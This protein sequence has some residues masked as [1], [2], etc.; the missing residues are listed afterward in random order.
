MS[1]TFNADTPPQQLYKQAM[2]EINRIAQE[3]G[4]PGFQNLGN[5]AMN[6]GHAIGFELEQL[7]KRID[8][9]SKESNPNPREY[10]QR[11]INEFAIPDGN[12]AQT[13]Q[14]QEKLNALLNKLGLNDAPSAGVSVGV[15]FVEE[16]SLDTLVL[17]VSQRADYAAVYAR[18][19]APELS[20]MSDE[21]P[22]DELDAFFDAHPALDRSRQADNA[23][24]DDDDFRLEGEEDPQILETSAIY[25]PGLR[26]AD[27]PAKPAREFGEHE[28]MSEFA[29]EVYEQMFSEDPF[30][31]LAEL[32]EQ[33]DREL[34][35]KSGTKNVVFRQHLQN[36]LPVVMLAMAG[37]REEW[38][39][40]NKNNA[41]NQAE[42][43]QR[44]QAM[45]AVFKMLQSMEIMTTNRSQFTQDHYQKKINQIMTLAGEPDGQRLA[46]ALDRI[47]SRNV[48]NVDDV[49]YN[50][51]QH[52]ISAFDPDKPS[53][54]MRGAARGLQIEHKRSE[55]EGSTAVVLSGK[56]H[57]S[58]KAV[59]GVQTGKFSGVKKVFAQRQDNLKEMKSQVSE[60]VNYALNDY[61]K[62]TSANPIYLQPANSNQSELQL[63]ILM[64]FKK[65]AVLEGRTL[66]ASDDD[67]N[68]IEITPS[69][70]FTAK[71]KQYFAHYAMKVPEVRVGAIGNKKADHPAAYHLFKDVKVDNKPLKDH[72]EQSPELL[73]KAM[74]SALKENV[75]FSVDRQKGLIE[76]AANQI[77]ERDLGATMRL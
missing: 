37:A 69:L 31:V 14:I 46:E 34:E 72:K 16:G 58:R 60:F 2:T 48:I 9:A 49:G 66:I 45:E 27:I 4:G 26:R 75:K 63:A 67:G 64:E 73:L 38:R 18:A 53:Q 30:N 43:L 8:D 5:G 50:Q 70:E 35:E 42:L 28:R 25:A 61:A 1:I 36:I 22:L 56:F 68:R 51:R 32:I 11:L 54:T 40:A 65:R 17:S 29:K 76:G 6:M 74:E 13:N 44:M 52:N 12:E 41:P 3:I 47:A 15:G 24:E 33:A 39:E 71:E 55:K 23:A 77:A 10:L 62:G 7:A 20:E 19:S 57:Y 21:D 59:I